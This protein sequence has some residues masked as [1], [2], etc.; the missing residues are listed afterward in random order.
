MCLKFEEKVALEPICVK[1]FS[2]STF[3]QCSIFFLDIPFV[4]FFFRYYYDGMNK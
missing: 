3:V 1:I 4:G 2:L